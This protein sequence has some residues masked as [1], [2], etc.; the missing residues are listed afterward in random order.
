[1]KLGSEVVHKPTGTIYI[2]GAKHGM[3][4]FWMM[5]AGGNKKGL[6]SAATIAKDFEVTQ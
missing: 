6:V 5:K 3:S 1:M 4:N 2:I